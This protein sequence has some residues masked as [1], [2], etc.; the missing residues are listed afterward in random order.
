MCGKLGSSVL[1]PTHQETTTTA[2]CVHYI[3]SSGLLSGEGKPGYV[4]PPP[5]NFFSR[6]VRNTQLLFLFPEVFLR[7][8]L[9]NTN[10]NLFHAN[11]L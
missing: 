8:L 1:L 9:N 3:F 2:V 4:P 10:I 11:F 6:K 7:W 5:P